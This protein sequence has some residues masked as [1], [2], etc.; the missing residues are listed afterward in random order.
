[1]KIFVHIFLICLLVI[2]GCG[3]GKTTRKDREQQVAY[4]EMAK[5][6]KSSI[7]DVRQKIKDRDLKKKHMVLVSEIPKELF[8]DW[9]L[10]GEYEKKYPADDITKIKN[11]LAELANN[12]F[13]K[14]AET[15][16]GKLKEIEKQLVADYDLSQKKESPKKSKKESPKKSEKEGK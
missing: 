9:K 11:D 12:Y 16:E 5:K 2:S 6:V 15:V 1:M 14:W 13:A 7:R 3:F 10:L 4:T 8:R